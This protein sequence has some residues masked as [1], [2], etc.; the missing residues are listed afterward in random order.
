[1]NDSYFPERLTE[2]PL[3]FLAGAAVSGAVVGAAVLLTDTFLWP[4]AITGALLLVWLV[5]NHPNAGLALLIFV[6]Y[7]RFSDV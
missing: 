5:F 1:M 7:T 2:T 3:F 6:T 4:V